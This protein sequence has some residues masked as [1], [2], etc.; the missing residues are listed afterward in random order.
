MHSTTS[1]NEKNL[2]LPQRA[3]RRAN[4]NMKVRIISRVHTNDRGWRAA[5][6][7]HANQDE[8]SVVDP[9]KVLVEFGLEASIIEEVDA[10]ICHGE[11]GVEFVV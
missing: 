10:T 9:V 4:L 5:I 11:I 3:Q 6:G 2:L 8:I 1:T 7:E